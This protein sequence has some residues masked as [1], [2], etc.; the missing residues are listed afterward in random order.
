MD[1]NANIHEQVALAEKIIDL[2]PEQVEQAD[3]DR[4]AEL[5][6]ALHEWRESGG[7]D[8]YVTADDVLE[9]LYEMVYKPKMEALLGRI[10]EVCNESGLIA[11]EPFDMSGDDYKWAMR[12]WRSQ[13]DKDADD[14]EKSVDVSVEIAESREYDGENEYGINFGV[15]IVEWGG[16]MLGGF[17]PFNYTDRCWVDSRDTDS[18]S[19]R[20]QLLED[21]DLDEIPTLIKE[22]R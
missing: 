18:V 10:R 19:E 7:F 17:T 9:R 2:E 5:V 1:P 20:W 3:I 21:A 14:D 6:V 8:P 22:E 13:A 16:R 11:D 4:L 15:D 12:V